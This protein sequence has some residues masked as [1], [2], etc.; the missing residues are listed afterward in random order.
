[1]DRGKGGSAVGAARRNH[2][3]R[4]NRLLQL[5]EP[6]K[7]VPKNAE[8]ESGL[9]ALLEVLTLTLNLRAREFE[10]EILKILV[11]YVNTPLL[12]IDLDY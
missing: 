3:S 11:I 5:L 7:S 12:R 2:W 8:G 1:M 4:R 10:D 9:S 6:S